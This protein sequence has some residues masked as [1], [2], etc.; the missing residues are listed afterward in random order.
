MHAPAE[1]DDAEDDL[2]VVHDVQLA[3]PWLDA[4]ASATATMAAVKLQSLAAVLQAVASLAAA[5]QVAMF[6]ATQFSTTWV[7]AAV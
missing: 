1:V 6:E 4:H 7:T 3:G 2:P 5:L